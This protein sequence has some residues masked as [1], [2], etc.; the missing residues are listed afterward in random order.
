MCARPRLPVV[1]TPPT[2][3]PHLAPYPKPGPPKGGWDFQFGPYGPNT[4][5]KKKGGRRKTRRGKSKMGRKTRR[6][7]SKMGR[8]TRRTR[9]H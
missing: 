4:A 8:K 7:K 2:E 6:G 5:P 3:G 9:K 1:N